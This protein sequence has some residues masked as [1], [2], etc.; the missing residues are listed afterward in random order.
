MIAALSEAAA[1]GDRSENEEYMS[2]TG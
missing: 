1:E 2:P